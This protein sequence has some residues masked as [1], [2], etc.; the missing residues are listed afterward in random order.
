MNLINKFLAAILII[1]VL[2]S[3]IYHWNAVGLASG[4]KPYTRVKQ[5]L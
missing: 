4:V 3:A 1:V 2:A 5:S